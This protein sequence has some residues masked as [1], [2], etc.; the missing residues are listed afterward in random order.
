M[1]REFG[2]RH[3]RQYD[4]GLTSGDG[5]GSNERPVKSL[6]ETATQPPKE[7]KQSGT[8]GIGGKLGVLGKRNLTDNQKIELN[9]KKDHEDAISG[10]WSEHYKKVVEAN[11]KQSHII[12]A[13]TKD[14]LE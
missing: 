1:D 2:D 13:F 6:V 14:L 3:N 11:N 9:T 8:E 12:R 10:V 7:T 5:G 4:D